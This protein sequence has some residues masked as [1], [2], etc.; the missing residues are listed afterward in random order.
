MEEQDWDQDHPCV[1]EATLED[2]LT[3]PSYIRSLEMEEDSNPV[4][5]YCE[6]KEEPVI[7]EEES[8]VTPEP[9]I[10]NDERERKS[11]E[12]N[13]V[14]M[15][16]R[17]E[18]TIESMKTA[19]TKGEENVRLENAKE[20]SD[21]NVKML[22]DEI[23]VRRNLHI[24]SCLERFSKNCDIVLLE[25]ESAGCPGEDVVGMT[26]S[27]RFFGGNGSPPFRS[28]SQGDR[29]TELTQ[30]V[31]CLSNLFRSLS[32][33]AINHA[34]LSRHRDF[35]RALSGLLLLR[36]KHRLR[37]AAKPSDTPAPPLPSV[38]AKIKDLMEVKEISDTVVIKKEICE[39]VP[40]S[41]MNGVISNPGKDENVEMHIKSLADDRVAENL[42]NSQK[43]IKK[44]NT[45]LENGYNN[46]GEILDH[47]EESSV[48][49][50]KQLTRESRKLRWAENGCD[51]MM[52]NDDVDDMKIE[53][54]R[55]A[56]TR[57]KCNNN[58]D[59]VNHLRTKSKHGK[60]AIRLSNGPCKLKNDVTDRT[61]ENEIIM[62][63]NMQNSDCKPLMDSTVQTS[64]KFSVCDQ[65]EMEKDEETCL[66]SE[67][68]GKDEESKSSTEISELS[69]CTKQSSVDLKE[70]I[71]LE[72][73]RLLFSTTVLDCGNI[74]EKRNKVY[75]DT[76]W[77]DCVQ[78]LREDSL[79][80]LANMSPYLDLA[81]LPDDGTVLAILD[82]CMHLV[83]CT[84]AE[85]QDP[86]SSMGPR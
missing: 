15:V 7:K 16:E 22:D 32:C 52:H 17:L 63:G 47:E 1:L 76:W 59:T 3:V 4:L 46:I 56:V 55:N 48:S 82:S 38:V 60:N 86:F 2:I 18:K 51:E 77:W 33:S 54:G 11:A 61:E 66:D 78:Q 37:P 30:M 74:G 40:E 31:L 83:V 28:K 69:E 35:M 8:S 68:L 73:K 45:T 29:E 70:T 10:L 44:E 81:K 79:V 34:E 72:R 26:R 53:K 58:H 13:E 9:M 71:K 67:D 80:A 39:I 36:H 6:V 75:S 42:I 41:Q 27:G 85:A 19:V 24:Q 49:D 57:I 65:V 20:V 50:K 23:G 14:N 21:L 64:G 84:S 12:E 25:D 43:L 62:A 5:G